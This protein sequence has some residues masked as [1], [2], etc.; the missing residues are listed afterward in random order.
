MTERT[1][2]RRAH[3]TA[4]APTDGDEDLGRRSPAYPQQVQVATTSP[5]RV[6]PLT[7]VLGAAGCL[8]VVAAG[9]VRLGAESPTDLVVADVTDAERA[10]EELVGHAGERGVPVIAFCAPAAAARGVAAL[11][12]G[13]DDLLTGAMGAQEVLA[14]VRAAARRRPGTPAA[15]PPRVLTG[16]PVTLDLDRRRVE[17]RGRE[18]MLTALEFKLLAHLMS[19]ADE[20]QAREHLLE[21]VW[22]YSTGG[23]ATVTVHV[24]HLRE[25]IEEDPAHPALIHTVWGTGYRFSSVEPPDDG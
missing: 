17:V 20:P 16:G 3:L 2:H 21:A 1:G 25:K 4:G 14:R 13:A 24:R 18:V 10:F 23:T 9:P 5:M 6:R 15:A 7:E 19:H 12:A 11:D 8:V 22:G